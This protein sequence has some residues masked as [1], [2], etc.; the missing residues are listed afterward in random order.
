VIGNENT[1]LQ[2]HKQFRSRIPSGVSKEIRCESVAVLSNE[3]EKSFTRTRLESRA[4]EGDS[5]V[6]KK[7]LF[8]SSGS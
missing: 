6:L 3:G 2:D 5:P 1:G 7:A 4:R 8:L